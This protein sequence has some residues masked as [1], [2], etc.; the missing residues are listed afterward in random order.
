MGKV[1][2]GY[3][4]DQQ[5]PGPHHHNQPQTGSGSDLL[6]QLPAHMMYIYLVESILIC[7]VVLIILEITEI[8][9]QW[10]QLLALV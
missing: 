1:M 5:A 9:R 4:W 10:R 3:H 7:R 6:A 2:V 8:G